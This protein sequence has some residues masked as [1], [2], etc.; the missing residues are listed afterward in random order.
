[1][2]N[3]VKN[4]KRL[5]FKQVLIN[6]FKKLPFLKL[7]RFKQLARTSSIYIFKKKRP[8]LTIIK[9]GL[10]FLMTKSKFKSLIT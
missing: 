2:Q 5:T 7:A 8:A 6:L 10:F 1:M 3:S 9:A 4:E